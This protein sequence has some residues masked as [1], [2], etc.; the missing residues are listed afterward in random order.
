MKARNE[1]KVKLSSFNNERAQLQNALEKKRMKGIQFEKEI[2]SLKKTISGLKDKIGNQRKIFEAKNAEFEREKLTFANKEKKFMNENRKKDAKLTNLRDKFIA[3]QEK[4]KQGNAMI[5][6]KYEKIGNLS[7]SDSSKNSIYSS[8]QN[9]FMTLVAKTEDGSF[10]KIKNEN[11]I[12]R[13]ALKE[14]QGMMTE[15]VETRRQMIEK[16]L[17]ECD[18]DE[19]NENISRIKE[20]LFNIKGIPLSTNTLI[21]VR[22]NIK[23]FRQFMED[24]DV[25]KLKNINQESAL[26]QISEKQS[27]EQYSDLIKNFKYIINNQ[28]SLL[29]K[30]IDTKKKK[31]DLGHMGIKE[32]LNNSEQNVSSIHEKLKELQRRHTENGNT[33]EKAR[34]MMNDTMGKLEREKEIFDVKYFF[35]IEI[36]IFAIEF[37]FSIEIFIFWDRNFFGDGV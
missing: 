6:N 31:L 18:F 15:V 3:L 5:L 9:D 13:K 36:F 32:K 25:I 22:E 11:E 34:K 1:D 26:G 29:K 24:L 14:L 19:E 33:F 20:E 30:A 12:L 4:Q 17:G 2:K 21:E 7:I 23:K 27:L 10:L 37:F 16:N 8:A 35:S 28:N